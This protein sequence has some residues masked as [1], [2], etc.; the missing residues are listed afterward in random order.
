[1]PPHARD[2]T[3]AEP[4]GRPGR[5]QTWLR[6]W[7]GPISGGRDGLKR[8]SHT[9][10]VR[11]A[12]A[13]VMGG[14]CAPPAAGGCVPKRGPEG[15]PQAGGVIGGGGW[16]VTGTAPRW[17]TARARN[18]P[19]QESA[20]QRSERRSDRGC[21]HGRCTD[22]SATT[23]AGPRVGST[24]QDHRSIK[25]TAGGWPKERDPDPHQVCKA[26]CHSPFSASAVK[27]LAA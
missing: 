23:A 19:L 4:R 12:A 8:C 6:P 21:I 11:K 26:F 27:A 22:H 17:G 13:P 24:S 20:D 14:V 15:A 25:P 2:R 3:A 16:A 9:G 5:N 18:D 7:L 1:M 10:P